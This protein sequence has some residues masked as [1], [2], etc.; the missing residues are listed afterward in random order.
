MK[1]KL[2]KFSCLRCGHEWNP[3]NE[4][5]PLRCAFCKSPYWQKAPAREVPQTAKHGEICLGC[6][7]KG[8]P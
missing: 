5:K 1:V 7:E 8:R 2:P 3:R 6:R 4:E